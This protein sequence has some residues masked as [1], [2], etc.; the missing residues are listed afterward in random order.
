MSGG[1]TISDNVVINVNSVKNGYISYCI[2]KMNLD[3]YRL[4][5]EYPELT[6]MPYFRLRPESAEF[7]YL[8]GHSNWEHETRGD[9]GRLPVDLLAVLVSLLDCRSF[10]ELTQTCKVFRI[11]NLIIEESIPIQFWYFWGTKD[12]VWK[13]L[14]TKEGIIPTQQWTPEK[15]YWLFLF[16]IYPVA[17]YKHLWIK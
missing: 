3:T 4:E 10:Q 6:C 2:Q 11:H 8:E 7:P 12:E 16:P 5:N 17:N 14:L 13:S 15:D 9:F 1:L